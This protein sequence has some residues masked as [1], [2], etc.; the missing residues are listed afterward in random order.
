MA[1]V[2]VTAAA[3]NANALRLFAQ[4]TGISSSLWRFRN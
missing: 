2:L 1:A 3:A 4:L